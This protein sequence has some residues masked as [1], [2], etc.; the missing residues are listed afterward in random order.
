MIVKKKKKKSTEFTCPD[1]GGTRIG[2]VSLSSL[3]FG[4]R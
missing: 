1:P 3:D 2:F 4:I